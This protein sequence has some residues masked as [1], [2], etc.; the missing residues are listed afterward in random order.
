LVVAHVNHGL[1]GRE[2]DAD[3]DFVHDLVNRL[4]TT[5]VSALEWRCCRLDAASLARQQGG[6]LEAVARAARYDWLAG[7]AREQGLGW[8]ATGHTADGQA[9]TVLHRLLRGSGLQ[10]LRGIPI[11]RALANDVQVVR[12]LLRLR[13][14]EVLGFLEAVQQPFRTDST[15]RDR[16]YT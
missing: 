9:E 4:H 7:L 13:R 11:Q 10:G 8:V 5:E 15:N 3:G 1:R 16:R 2:S 14:A 12:P 6:N